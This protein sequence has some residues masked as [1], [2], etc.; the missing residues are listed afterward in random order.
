MSTLKK[1]HLVRRDRIRNAEINSDNSRFRWHHMQKQNQK[2]SNTDTDQETECGKIMPAKY[3]TTD[4]KKTTCD[5]C[6]NKRFNK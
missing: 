5:D 2:V 1:I 4:P 3:F 6:L